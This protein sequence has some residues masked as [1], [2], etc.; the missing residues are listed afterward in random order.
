MDRC[1]GSHTHIHVHAAVWFQ[2]GLV[3]TL[4]CFYESFLD[5][6]YGLGLVQ[7]QLL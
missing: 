6:V 3:K 1:A 2:K 4:K 5:I 7:A